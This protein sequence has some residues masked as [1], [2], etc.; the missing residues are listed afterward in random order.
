MQRFNPRS[1]R[2]EYKE[3]VDRRDE[4]IEELKEKSQKFEELIYENDKN[5]H[6]LS[7]LFECDVIDCDGKLIKEDREHD[8]L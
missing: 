6:I 8:P 5:S 1:S 2:V 4:A 7:K 3:E